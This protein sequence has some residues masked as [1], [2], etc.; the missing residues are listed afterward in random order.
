M[1]L[2][3]VRN[4]T[5]AVRDVIAKHDDATLQR[6]HDA[7]RIVVSCS[8]EDYVAVTCAIEGVIDD[9]RCRIELAEHV[10]DEAPD[11]APEDYTSAEIV[12]EVKADLAAAAELAMPALPEVLVEAKE[13]PI[14]IFARIKRWFT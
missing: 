7:E 5:Q 3:L 6:E 8:D 13:A 1:F 4:P 11:K 2:L 14:G 9:Q 10:P 12:A